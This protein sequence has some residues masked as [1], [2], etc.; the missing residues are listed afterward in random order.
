ML[1]SVKQLGSGQ[2][3]EL[4]GIS[5]GSKLCAYGTA[6]KADLRRHSR[7]ARSMATEDRWLFDTGHLYREV[8]I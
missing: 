4:L 8:L 5:S 6:V 7:E 3:D 2:D 1:Q